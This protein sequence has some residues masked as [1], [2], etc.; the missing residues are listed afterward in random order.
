ML[1]LKDGSSHMLTLKME[2]RA[3]SKINIE[4]LKTQL[5]IPSAIVDINGKG[6]FVGC[7]VGDSQVAR[8]ELEEFAI[9]NEE[10]GQVEPMSDA[11]DAMDEDL[12]GE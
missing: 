3:V 5:A 1:V 7:A 9:Q 12:E 10:N 11:K 2:G 4:R 6:V 8:L